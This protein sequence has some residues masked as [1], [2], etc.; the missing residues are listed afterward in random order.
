MREIKFRAWKLSEKRMIYWEELSESSY[1][2]DALDR[3]YLEEVMQYIGLKDDND[4][5]YYIGDIGEFENGDRFILRMEDWLEVYVYWIGE[6]E[7]EDQARYLYKIESA[8]II[9]NE[10]ENPELLE[11]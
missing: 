3:I 4:K 10:F 8:K 11:D 9:G 5:K 6:T 7:C 2:A 1:L